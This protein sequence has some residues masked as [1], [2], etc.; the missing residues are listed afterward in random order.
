MTEKEL[1]LILMKHGLVIDQWCD[2][3][4]EFIVTVRVKKD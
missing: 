1:R 2:F 4:T 3:E